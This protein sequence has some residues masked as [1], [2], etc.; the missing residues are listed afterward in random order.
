M[1]R[2]VQIF[3]EK[4]KHWG[5]EKVITSDEKWE[6]YDNRY[7]QFQWL[8]WA[9]HAKSTP[10]KAAGQRNLPLCIYWNITRPVHW[11][12][13][14]LGQTVSTDVY[15]AQLERVQTAIEKT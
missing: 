9:E 8:D 12:L 7:Q 5:L 6:L 10:R 15:L 1:C 11:K 14:Q 13:L 4:F 3:A 2:R